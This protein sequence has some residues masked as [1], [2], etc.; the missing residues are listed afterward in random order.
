MSGTGDWMLGNP[1]G[2]PPPGFSVP[3]LFRQF[4]YSGCRKQ[5]AT[6]RATRRPRRCVGLP[7][8]ITCIAINSHNSTLTQNASR[9][10]IV[11]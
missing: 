11:D 4:A 3:L 8:Y 7:F 2:I 10:R 6:L 1:K 9:Q 5:E